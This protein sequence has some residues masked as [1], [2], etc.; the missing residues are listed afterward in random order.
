LR[1][2]LHF[3]VPIIQK[4]KAVKKNSDLKFNALKGLILHQWQEGIGKKSGCDIFKKQRHV[5]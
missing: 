5:R 4:E 1:P 2:H 3:Y